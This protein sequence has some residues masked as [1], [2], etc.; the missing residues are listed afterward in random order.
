MENSLKYDPF[1]LTIGIILGIV[2]IV[3]K[4]LFTIKSEK[5]KAI[6][7]NKNK[8]AK[9]YKLINL[10]FEY[11]NRDSVIMEDYLFTPYTFD[12]FIDNCRIHLLSK[13]KSDCE[14]HIELI[15]NSTIQNP[16]TYLYI[17]PSIQT[18]ESKLDVLNRA[19]HTDEFEKRLFN[20]YS[21]HIENNIKIGEKI[22]EEAIEY[23]KTFGIEPPGDPKLHPKDKENI[24]EEDIKDVDLNE[25]LKMGVVEE[26]NDELKE[27]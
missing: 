15:E 22:E 21:D 18:I 25:L 6:E 26:Y 20:I 23:N 10:I 17:Y 11:I 5:N 1:I 4:N 2:F 14:K 27:I 24:I 12:M 7:N 19:L 3:I 13:F 9:D 16:I 8:I